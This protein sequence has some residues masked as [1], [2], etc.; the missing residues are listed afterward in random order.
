[1]N[2]HSR[3]ILM[4]VSRCVLCVT[5]H[6]RRK[7]LLVPDRAR[8][9]RGERRDVL[10]LENVQ[11]PYV[12]F[13]RR[14]PSRDDK[15][16]GLTGRQDR[17][18][19]LLFLETRARARA[20]DRS[21]VAIGRFGRCARRRIP[22]FVSSCVAFRDN[23]ESRRVAYVTYVR[24]VIE[25][26]AISRA[27][28]LSVPPPLLPALPRAFARKDAR[29]QRLFSASE[30]R[31]ELD[32]RKTECLETFRRRQL[33]DIGYYYYY[34]YYYYYCYHY[35]NDD[36]VQCRYSVRAYRSRSSE[37]TSTYRSNEQGFSGT[38]SWKEIG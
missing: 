23:R 12:I 37:I 20:R 26:L 19:S 21:I 38:V 25:N 3:L 11:N 34:Y 36:N 24:K 8:P 29:N 14:A 16:L 2:R 22:S 30:M 10:R 35:Y 17:G 31:A 4:T 1:M 27:T 5:L 18:T 32:N 7:W 6:S 28:R 33:S 9:Q 15:W 13:Y